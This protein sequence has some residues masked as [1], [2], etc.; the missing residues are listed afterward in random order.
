MANTRGAWL[1]KLR[2]EQGLTLK[3]AA[4][5]A[6]FSGQVLSRIERD[7]RL[8]SESRLKALCDLYGVSPADAPSAKAKENARKQMR[9]KF[10]LAASYAKM[11]RLY[12]ASDDLSRAQACLTSVEKT[13][14]ELLEE[15][16]A[17]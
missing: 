3:E 11:S 1:R 14:A 7:K 5:A 12:I 13:L 15:D 9:I 8:I 10:E 4:S 16:L 6:G 2:S 17:A